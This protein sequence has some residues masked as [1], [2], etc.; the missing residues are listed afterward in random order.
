[1]RFED[2][3]DLV[4]YANMDRRPDK[5][6]WMEVQLEREGIDAHRIAGP[7]CNKYLPSKLTPVGYDETGKAVSSDERTGMLGALYALGITVSFARIANAKSLLYFEDDAVLCDSFK[8]RLTEAMNHAPE[9]WHAINFGG[10]NLKEPQYVNDWFG[11]VTESLNA[12]CLLFHNSVFDLVIESCRL[13]TCL[14]D[15]Q[16]MKM[17]NIRYF[18]STRFHIPQKAGYSDTIGEY[19]GDDRGR[20]DVEKW[21]EQQ[22]SETDPD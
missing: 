19:L 10:W 5:R 20:F 17:R 3:V 2:Y 7:D 9:G 18:A 12:H 6:E 21:A 8:Q 11:L 1:M 22:A 16:L 4:C 14:P 13:H 15:E